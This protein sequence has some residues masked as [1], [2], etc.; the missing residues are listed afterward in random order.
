MVI[1]QSN[2]D[3]SARLVDRKLA[4]QVASRS[5]LLDKGESAVR[6]DGIV[7]QRIG[8]DGSSARAEGR[9]V[10]VQVADSRGD[11]KFVIALKMDN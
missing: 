9:D 2:S 6:V 7:D 10:V 1:L 11:E 3:T 5:N 8:L 4:W